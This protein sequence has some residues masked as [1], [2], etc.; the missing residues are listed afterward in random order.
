VKIG[1][2]VGSAQVQG[3]LWGSAARDWAE[4]QEP[5]HRPLREAQE[6]PVDDDSFD[7]VRST[8]FLRAHRQYLAVEAVA[9]G[10]F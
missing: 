2:A 3:E 9:T 5:M 7:A 8:A 4:L 6:L 10:T 1:G